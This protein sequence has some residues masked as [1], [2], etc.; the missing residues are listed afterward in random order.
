[1]AEMAE[2]H[3][4]E[5]ALIGSKRFILKMRGSKIHSFLD[6]RNINEPFLADFG[7][8]PLQDPY[9]SGPS[10]PFFLTGRHGDVYEHSQVGC[11]WPA[12]RK[13]G[14]K[15]GYEFIGVMVIW[16]FEKLEAGFQKV[17]DWFL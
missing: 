17:S 16:L 10:A 2:C 13:G 5:M 9:P 4:I 6:R 3:H 12:G 11:L 15:S 1:M 14:K 8:P 7:S